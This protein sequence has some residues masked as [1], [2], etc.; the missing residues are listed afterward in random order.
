MQIEQIA[1]FDLQDDDILVVSLPDGITADAYA[2]T[3]KGLQKMI[4]RT[5]V[6]RVQIVFKP[7]DCDVQII[8]PGGDVIY[9]AA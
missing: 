7:K 5:G 3:R 9:S 1:K 4:D 6:R 8:R 2:S